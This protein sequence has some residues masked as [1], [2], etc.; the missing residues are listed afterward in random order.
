VVRPAPVPDTDILALLPVERR[1]PLLNQVFSRIIDAAQRVIVLVGADDWARA[2]RADRYLAALKP[3]A[4]L[5]KWPIL[6]S[7]T[8]ADWLAHFQPYRIAL[9]TPSRGGTGKRPASYYRARRA[10]CIVRSADP[11]RFLAGRSIRFIR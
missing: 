5:C 9:I 1:D 2:N 11:K 10:N 3:H 6:G 8:Q 4:D 7:K